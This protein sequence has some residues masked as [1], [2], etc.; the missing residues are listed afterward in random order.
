MTQA[1]VQIAPS[2]GADFD[3]SSLLHLS[4][5]LPMPSLTLEHRNEI[6]HGS[7]NTALPALPA[8][9]NYLN[10]NQLLMMFPPNT[11]DNNTTTHTSMITPREKV[12][13]NAF[14]PDKEVTT[15]EPSFITLRQGE[16]SM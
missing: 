6:F 7:G 10:R 13:I 1:L 4:T 9:P 11:S 5:M 15:G 8:L 16:Q 2:L 12:N 14:T 3:S